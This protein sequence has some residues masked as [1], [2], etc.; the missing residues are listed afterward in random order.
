MFRRSKNRRKNEVDRS[1][2]MIEE[3]LRKFAGN[4]PLL[5]NGKFVTRQDIER[6]MERIR[7]KR[8]LILDK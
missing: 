1:R 8:K 3:I 5:K 7:E 4:D 2:K 6:S